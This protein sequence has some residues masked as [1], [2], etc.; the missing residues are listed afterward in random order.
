MMAVMEETK[1]DQLSVGTKECTV[2]KKESLDPLVEV[3]FRDWKE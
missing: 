1:D 3:Y 2:C